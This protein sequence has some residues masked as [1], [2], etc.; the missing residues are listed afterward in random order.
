MHYAKLTEI[1]FT[2]TK[3]T[4]GAIYIIR[5]PRNIITSIC[6]H[7]Q[8]RCNEAFEFMNKNKKH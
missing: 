7:Y 5:D 3:N 6:N 4:L 8:I 1:S 2:D